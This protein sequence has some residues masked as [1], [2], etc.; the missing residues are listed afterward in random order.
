[1]LIRCLKEVRKKAMSTWGGEE[2]E[3]VLAERTVNT[4][5]LRQ[6]HAWRA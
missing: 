5:A 4:K 3:G 2:L 6:E 1:M